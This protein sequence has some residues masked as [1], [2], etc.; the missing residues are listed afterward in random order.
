MRCESKNIYNNFNIVNL[1]LIKQLCVLLVSQDEAAAVLHVFC[2]AAVCV[3]YV[4]VCVCDGGI[5]HGCT[6]E[7]ALRWLSGGTL[8]CSAYPS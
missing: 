6:S 4:C 8:I 1:R 3:V 7:Q 5:S 2:L